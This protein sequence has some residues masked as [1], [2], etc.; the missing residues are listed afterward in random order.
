LSER[1]RGTAS[2]QLRSCYRLLLSKDKL[3]VSDGKALL[4]KLADQLMNEINFRTQAP[5]ELVDLKRQDDYLFQH[6]VNTAAFSILLGQSMQYNQMKL[7]DIAVSALLCDLG[8]QFIE[9]EIVRKPGPLSEAEMEKVRSHAV[10]GFQHLGRQC[11]YKGLVTIVA[12]QHHERWDGSGYTQKLTGNDIHEYSRIV[13]VADFFDA[14]TSDRHHR[15]LHT[16]PEAIDYIKQ[17]SGK[18]FDPRVVKHLLN[19]FRVPHPGDDALSWT[20][21]DTTSNWGSV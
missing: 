17:Q 11:F 18:E 6:A 14:Y 19:F 1:T 8:M 16:I 2:A 10:L 7:F 3:D 9:D 15:P 21:D 5:P 4:S 20:S 13:S 12:L